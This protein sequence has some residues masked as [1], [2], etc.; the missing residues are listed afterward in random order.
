MKEHSHRTGPAACH[1]RAADA[2]IAEVQ[3]SIDPQPPRTVRLILRA[4]GAAFAW[5]LIG[6]FTAS[7]WYIMFMKAYGLF[8]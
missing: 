7:M 2:F 1:V 3:A 4:L 5:F 8:G 6:A